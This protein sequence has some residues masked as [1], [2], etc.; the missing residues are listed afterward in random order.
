[1]VDRWLMVAKFVMVG[2]LELGGSDF[3]K[4]LRKCGVEM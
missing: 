2:R 4:I 1:M 3:A